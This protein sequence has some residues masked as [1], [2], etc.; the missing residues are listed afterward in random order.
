MQ[1][2]LDEALGFVSD[3]ISEAFM[4][5]CTFVLGFFPDGDPAIFSAIDS[6]AFVPGASTFNLLYFVDFNAV[7]LFIGLAAAIPFVIIAIDMVKGT[8]D[9]VNGVLDKMPFKIGGGGASS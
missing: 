6:F 9:T 2:L 7:G 4:Q 8:I 1:G 3:E 5:F